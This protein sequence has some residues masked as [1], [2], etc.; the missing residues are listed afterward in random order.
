[1]SVL[2]RLR[3]DAQVR[4]A[5]DAKA[6]IRVTTADLAELRTTDHYLAQ[7]VLALVAMPGGTVPAGLLAST[8]ELYKTIGADR[9]ALALHA[10]HA[11]LGPMNDHQRRSHD[12]ALTRQVAAATVLDKVIQH[13]HLHGL[14]SLNWSMGAS[15]NLL[16]RVVRTGPIRT[17]H[18]LAVLA[19]WAW[20]HLLGAG[21]DGPRLTKRLDGVASRYAHGVNVGICYDYSDLDDPVVARWE[22]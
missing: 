16:G 15:C 8:L 4:A 1:M 18:G 21:P 7:R 17:S 12:G 9:R 22:D 20:F 11:A 13:G 3:R 5:V 14:P 6:T 19:Y 2:A 10:Y